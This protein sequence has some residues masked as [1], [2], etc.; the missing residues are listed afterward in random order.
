MIPAALTAVDM[1][2]QEADLAGFGVCWFVFFFQALVPI[3]Y[4]LLSVHLLLCL[5]ADQQVGRSYSFASEL[6]WYAAALPKK[7]EVVPKS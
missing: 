4:C 5:N 7:W 2:Y 3:L 1:Y 6:D